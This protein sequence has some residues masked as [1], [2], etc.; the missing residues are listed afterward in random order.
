M[1][2]EKQNKPTLNKTD[3][4]KTIRK[5]I[6]KKSVASRKYIDPIDRAQVTVH[7]QLTMRITCLHR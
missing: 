3:S 6:V 5:C 2:P 4:L 1:Q 7:H